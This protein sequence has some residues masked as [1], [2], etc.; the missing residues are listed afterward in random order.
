MRERRPPRVRSPATRIRG[1]A[2]ANPGSSL[3]RNTI[4]TGRRGSEASRCSAWCPVR[5]AS[6][7]IQRPR[8]SS[9]GHVV[10][11]SSADVEQKRRQIEQARPDWSSV[12]RRYVTACVWMGWLTKRRAA[13][14]DIQWVVEDRSCTCH[15]SR[16]PS[17]RRQPEEVD[18]YAVHEMD[19]DVDDVI[20]PDA[21][22]AREVVQRKAQVGDRSL[23]AIGS[24]GRRPTAGASRVASVRRCGFS[25]MLG[26]SSK[27]KGTS[28][29]FP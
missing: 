7:R 8:V 2:A 9:V 14:S 26:R 6:R 24:R 15:A 11:R 5:A 27:T 23:L 17:E 13:A 1:S 21:I 3:E 20:A 28:R 22:L 12:G 4:R 25:E 10:G 16:R 19:T 18:Q 29:L